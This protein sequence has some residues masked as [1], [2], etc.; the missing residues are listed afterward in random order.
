LSGD[1]LSEKLSNELEEDSN[2]IGTEFTIDDEQVDEEVVV[3]SE[4][5]SGEKGTVGEVNAKNTIQE[6]EFNYIDQ[7]QADDG[8]SYVED[9][10]ALRDDMEKLYRSHYIK[11]KCMNKIIRELNKLWKQES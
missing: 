3:E 8:S 10:P 11:T 1:Q 7:M 4:A 6:E 5:K 9:Q 2:Q